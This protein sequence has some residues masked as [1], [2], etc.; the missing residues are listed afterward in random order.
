MHQFARAADIVG[1]HGVVIEDVIH[2]CAV[3]N[4][5]VRLV[6]QALPILVVQ[7]ELFATQIAAR[8]TH[9]GMKVLFDFRGPHVVAT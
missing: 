6:G 3:V 7:A 1:P 2:H 8:D 9:A 5:R 4:N